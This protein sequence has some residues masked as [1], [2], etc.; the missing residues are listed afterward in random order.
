MKIKY[1]LMREDYVQYYLHFLEKRRRAIQTW[2]YRLLVGS[3]CFVF[4]A[5]AFSFVLA[6]IRAATKQPPIYGPWSYT[7]CAF[8]AAFIVAISIGIAALFMR[9][10]DVY[11]KYK[12]E[13]IGRVKRVVRWAQRNNRT[14]VG[15]SCEIALSPNQLCMTAR[16]DWVENGT[17]RTSMVTNAVDWSDVKSID[18]FQIHAFIRAIPFGAFFVPQT[19]FSD[20]AAFRQFLETAKRLWKNK[21]TTA[22]TV[23]PTAGQIAT[24]QIP[25]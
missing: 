19:A 4:L 5:L 14:F 6:A 2:Q 1:V 17:Q 8:L 13:E 20:A 3:I 9:V 21:P 7:T 16:R 24:D 11:G 22:I 10:F 12:Q 18:E 23:L 15:Y 25:N